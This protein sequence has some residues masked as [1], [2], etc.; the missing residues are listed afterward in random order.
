MEHFF[1]RKFQKDAYVKCK[2]SLKP[3]QCLM[4]QDFAKNRDIVFQDEIK[5]NFWV[6]K[7]VTL[8]PSVLFYRLT[9]DQKDPNKLVITHLSDNKNHDAHM[10]HL[11]TQDCIS[12]LQNKHPEI[13]WNEII[14]WSDGCASQ[15]KGENSFYYLDKYSVSVQR[16][17]F[18]S[19]HGKG[20][21]DAETGLI[22]MKLQA[23]VKSRSAVLQ[24]A[25]SMLDFLLENHS[26]DT[27]LYKLVNE[28]DLN[29]IMDIFKDVT[30]DTL[31]GKCTRSL[32]Q[33]KKSNRKGI[34]LERRYTCLCRF[35]EDDDFNNCFN[36]QYTGGSFNKRKLP[37][38]SRDKN[39]ENEDDEYYDDDELDMIVNNTL[40][41]DSEIKIPVI[42]EE[43]LLENVEVGDFAVVAVPKTK[44]DIYSHWIYKI[45]R[46]TGEEEIYG[47]A[48]KW[49]HDKRYIFYKTN[50]PEQEFDLNNIMMILPEPLESRARYIFPGHIE[51]KENFKMIL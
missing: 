34:L 25:K 46:V 26:D 2:L 39:I 9:E 5:S 30:V 32:H 48:Y 17:Y 45:S 31:D 49:D 8:H 1:A 50:E 51:L 38:K 10:V 15:Y 22:S 27:H 20:P 42:R 19:E 18:E 16:N 6:K 23:A 36:Q 40:N 35:C 41:E 29:E 33:I 14:V 11:M 43:L 3:G 13:K 37:I 21:S 24:D 44:K 28:E 7:Q 12:I 47:Y 4:V